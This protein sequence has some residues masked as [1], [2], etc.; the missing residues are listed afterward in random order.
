MLKGGIFTVYRT[1]CSWTKTQELKSPSPVSHEILHSYNALCSLPKVRNAFLLRTAGQL[2]TRRYSS[3]WCQPLSPRWLMIQWRIRSSAC[4]VLPSA[5]CCTV[6]EHVGPGQGTVTS[7]VGKWH[8]ASHASFALR[9]IFTYAWWVLKNLHHEG[10]SYSISGKFFLF[11]RNLCFAWLS[12]LLPHITGTDLFT[13]LCFISE[14]TLYARKW[15]GR[16]N[17]CS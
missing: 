8:G 13:Q 2:G 11:S 16:V 5:H 6:V 12:S 15:R 7:Q 10:M 17:S 1:A 3:C 9:L 4:P 14:G